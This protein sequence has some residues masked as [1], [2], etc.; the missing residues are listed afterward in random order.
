M[1]ARGVVQAKSAAL[2]A[3][4]LIAAIAGVAFFNALHLTRDLA[5]TS[6]SAQGF[7]V[8]HAIAN[9]NALLS[10]WHFPIDNFYLTDSLMYAAGEL[11]AG[12]QPHL[13]ASIPALVY[14]LFV[15]LTLVVCVRRSHSLSDNLDPLAA[16]TLLLAA[17]AWIGAWDPMLMSDMHTATALAA[18]VALVLYARVA[19]AGFRDNVGRFAAVIA[20]LLVAV[21]VASDPFSLVFALGPAAVVFAIESAR[22]RDVRNQG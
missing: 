1:L 12:S 14:A 22:D 7:V 4:V 9:G 15:L 13:L 19:T 20:V 10:D 18:L 2:I 8:G 11:I 5:Q 16:A 6:D 17:P 21:T 3:A